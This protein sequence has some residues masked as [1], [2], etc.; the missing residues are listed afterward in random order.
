[1]DLYLHPILLHGVHRDSFR[2]NFRNSA[3]KEESKETNRVIRT[4]DRN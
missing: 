3:T 4:Q 2:N 1:V